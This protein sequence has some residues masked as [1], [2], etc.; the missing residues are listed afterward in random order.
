MVPSA[1]PTKHTY[2][3]NGLTVDWPF[4]F[5]IATTDGSDILIYLTNPTTGYST[6]LTSNYSVNVPGLSVKYPTV[7]SGLPALPATWKITLIRTEDIVQLMN[8][9]NQGA[10]NA[11]NLETAFD[12]LT[13]ICQQLNEKM[14]RA[15][16]QD[17]TAIAPITLTTLLTSIDP[18]QFSIAAA[19]AIA[20]MNALL[21]AFPTT[22]GTF[23]NASLVAGKLTITHSKNLAA[24]YS[25]LIHIYN[26]LGKVI[27]PDAVTGSANSHEVDLTNYGAL[28]G[29]WGYIYQ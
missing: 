22:R 21:A 24:P 7:A 14:D 6:L 1:T 20:Q 2:S 16:L 8:L 26:N 9:L 15:V 17:V 25:L 11:E 3:G 13:M 23:T 10:F 29:T 4:T 12:K 28:T 19:A 27:I 18:T 5:P